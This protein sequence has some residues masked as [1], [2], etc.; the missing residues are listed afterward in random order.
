VVVVPQQ[1]ELSGAR[2]VTSGPQQETFSEA[3][4]AT[5]AAGGQHD[6]VDVVVGQHSFLRIEVNFISNSCSHIKPS[7]R[8]LI[9]LA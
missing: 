8:A 9:L 1:D 4:T 5:F 2:T 6:E 7:A 3:G